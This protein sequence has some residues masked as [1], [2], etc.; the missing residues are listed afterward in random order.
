[1]LG[2]IFAFLAALF[3][4][5]GEVLNK[6][7]LKEVDEYA[8]GSGVVFCSFLVTLPLLWYYGIPEIGPAFVPALL[9]SGGINI[10]TILLQMKALKCSDLSVVSPMQ[11][12]APLFVLILSPFILGEVPGPLGVFGVLLIV[13]GSYF[14]HIKCHSRGVLEPL[15]ALLKDRGARMMLAVTMLWSVSTIFDKVGVLNSSPIFWSAAA[16]GFIAIGMNLLMAFHSKKSIRQI[17]PHMGSFFLIGLVGALTTIFQSAALGLIFASYVSAIK[18]FSIVLGVIFGFFIFREKNIRERLLG[19][20][21][22]LLGV[23]LIAL[24]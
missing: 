1:M 15:K 20:L 24:S 8:V 23:V 6:K 10:V 18:R 22:M 3:K 19:A 12:F 17:S 5:T 7:I 21:I 2:F 11:A 4:S 9:I 13:F 16:L 14:L